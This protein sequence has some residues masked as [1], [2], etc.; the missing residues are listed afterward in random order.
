MKIAANA[1]FYPH[2]NALIKRNRV[3]LKLC[4]AVDW[5]TNARIGAKFWVDSLN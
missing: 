1:S 3:G 5:T 2:T 4:V